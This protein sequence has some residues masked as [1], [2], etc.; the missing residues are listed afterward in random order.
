MERRMKE[1]SAKEHANPFHL[2]PEEMRQLGYRVVDALV[3][4]GSAIRDRPVL[5]GPV[6]G[7]GSADELR[8]L[9]RSFPAGP[10]DAAATIDRAIGTVFGNTMQ[11]MHPRFFAYF[12]GPGNFISA[13]ADFMAAGFNVFA[14]TAPHNEGAFEVERATIDWLGS[15]FGWDFPSGGLFVSSGSA[16]NFT[17][18][19]VARHIRLQDNTGD[20]VVYCSSQTHSCI[21]RGL[22]L[23]GFR[24]GQLRTIEAETDC[25]LPADALLKAIAADRAAGRRPFCVVG[26]CGTTNTAAIDPLCELADICERENL[27]FHVD[28][29]FGGGA[30]LSASARPLFAG[31]ERAHTIAVDPHKWMFQP[32]ECACVLGRQNDWF[33]ETFRRLP[34]YMRDTDASGD[35]FNYRDL[36]L[37]VTRSFKAFKLWLSLHVFGVDAF[38]KAVDKGLQLARYAED[39]VE[40]RD[41]WEVVSPASLGVLTFRYRDAHR[42]AEYV[43]RLN[44]QLAESISRSGFA[45]VTTT[46]LKGRRVLR[47]CPIHPAAN[48]A[49]IDETFARLE[50]SARRITAI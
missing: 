25:R 37:Q 14:G 47:I 31:I 6:R 27:W 35:Q 32:F 28:A 12:P 46:E 29:A 22:F 50:E 30:V 24:P 33:R 49:D 23:L 45:Y 15:Q 48:R 10:A 39:H 13:L 9:C 34:A 20:A 38:R 7:D 11:L 42:D 40:S 18:L 8:E 1:R 36:G 44:G 19:A 2:E 17:A 3:E 26:N 4:H 16:A 43:D 41:E 21:E 5:G